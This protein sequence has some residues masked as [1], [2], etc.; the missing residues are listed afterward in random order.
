MHRL[1]IG[2]IILLG[3]LG[4]PG[5]CT[6]T[7]TDDAISVCQPLCH[8][9]DSPLPSAQ[10][11]CAASCIMEFEQRPLGEACVTC[12]IDHADRCPS[13]LDDCSLACRQNMPLPSYARTAMSPESRS[14]R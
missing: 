13:L 12:V 14:T 10:R 2:W 3:L 11:A 4:L 9:T 1:A 7:V 6:P 8:C 5:A